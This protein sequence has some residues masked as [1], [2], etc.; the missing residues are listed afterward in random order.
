MLQDAYLTLLQQ[1]PAGA[2]RTDYFA[3]DF[4]FCFGYNL[5]F[6]AVAAGAGYVVCEMKHLL[7]LCFAEASLPLVLRIGGLPKVL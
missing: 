2:R 6:S 1:S 5:F 7:Y 3:A 4:V